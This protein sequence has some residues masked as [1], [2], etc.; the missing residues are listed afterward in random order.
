MNA[1]KSLVPN[2]EAARSRIVDVDVAEETANLVK[3]Q[4]L[5][6]IGAAVLAQANLISQLV[7]KLLK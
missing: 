2:A 5:Q 4:I 6:K 7:L 3:N 1:L